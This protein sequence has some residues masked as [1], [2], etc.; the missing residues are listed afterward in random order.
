MDFCWAWEWDSTFLLWCQKELFFKE[1]SESFVLRNLPH[2]ALPAVF[3]E[4]G[5]A[6]LGEIFLLEK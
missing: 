1:L 5:G 4:A 3:E 2:L 6:A